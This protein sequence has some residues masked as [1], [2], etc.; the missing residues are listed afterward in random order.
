MSD[1]PSGSIWQYLCP[2]RKKWVDVSPEED[3]QLKEA[4]LVAKA[5]SKEVQYTLHGVRFTVDFLEFTRTNVASQRVAPLQLRGGELPFLLQG[6]KPPTLPTSTGPN[7]KA[8]PGIAPDDLVTPDGK[9]VAVEVR[10][11]WGHG[12]P[13]GYTMSGTFEFTL[14]VAERDCLGELLSW[15]M[16]SA[17]VVPEKLQPGSLFFTDK[18]GTRVAGDRQA[19]QEMLDNDSSFPVKIKYEPPK[20]M[21]GVPLKWHL[22]VE[23]HRTHLAAVKRTVKELNRDIYKVKHQHQRKCFERYLL[24]LEDNL[25]QNGDDLEDTMTYKDFEKHFPQM[26]GHFGLTSKVIT[27]L[28]KV[29]RGEVDILEYLFG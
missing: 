17:G 5:G 29:M 14:Q 22:D 9:P 24:Y 11:A 1:F 27:E 3:L 18:R 2:F 10:K 4:Y 19:I 26:L 16:L 6:A 13:H 8:A 12:V 25:Y 23:V 28:P 15:Q 20:V 7:A 21:Q